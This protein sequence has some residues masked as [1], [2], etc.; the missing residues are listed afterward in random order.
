MTAFDATRITSCK[1]VIQAFKDNEE[2]LIE[3]NTHD[4]SVD[5]E[6]IP[7]PGIVNRQA[8]RADPSAVSPLQFSRRSVFLPFIDTV[9]D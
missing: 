8:D 3:L 5:R 6:S 4:E 2:I 1:D 7:M 9:L